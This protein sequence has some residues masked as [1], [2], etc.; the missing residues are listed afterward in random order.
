[1]TD[2]T[3]LSNTAVGVG[4]LPSG[5][6]VTALRDNPIAIVEGAPGAPRV[7][8]AAL[9]TTSTAAGT[10][11]VIK[12][13]AGAAVGAVGTY[14]LLGRVTGTI[15]SPGDTMAGSGLRYTGFLQQPAGD[16][17]VSGQV[18]GTPSGTW[19]AMGYSR[20]VSGFYA[21]TLFLRIS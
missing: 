2:Y 7:L 14:A 21:T 3:I 5:A 8:D 18:S 1:M 19:R 11:W 17:I 15:I 6:T 16:G 13:T 20:A 9:G 10:D 4:G 12:R